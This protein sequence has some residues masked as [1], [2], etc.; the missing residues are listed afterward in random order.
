M[1]A[2]AV[3]IAELLQRLAS[4]GS[5]NATEYE[6]LRAR[7]AQNAGSPD[8]PLVQYYCNAPL[9]QAPVSRKVP[10]RYRDTRRPRRCKA[11][12]AETNAPYGRCKIVCFQCGN[13]RTVFFG[14]YQ[15]Y[16]DQRLNGSNTEPSQFQ[17]QDE[18]V[19]DTPESCA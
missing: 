6:V 7:V 9:T 4:G 13:V 8:A 2:A 18:D 1:S 10:H 15:R 11:V 12:I 14:G 3:E 19:S 5:L 17:A 16:R